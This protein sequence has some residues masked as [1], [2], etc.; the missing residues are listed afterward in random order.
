MRVLLFFVFSAVVA[1]KTPSTLPEYAM[2]A[3]TGYL[4][5]TC[6]RDLIC[7][8]HIWDN[9]K[10]GYPVIGPGCYWSWM[11]ENRFYTSAS[12][13]STNHRRHG[14][15]EFRRLSDFP[16]H[17]DPSVRQAIA[18]SAATLQPKLTEHCPVNKDL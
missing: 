12:A 11:D 3:T 18:Q 17:R 5:L 8:P 1:T 16:G 13:S 10:H 4:T 2:M 6:P 14:G 7:W 9:I 15:E